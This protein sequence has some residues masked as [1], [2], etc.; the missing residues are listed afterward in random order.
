VP[1]VELLLDDELDG[2]VSGAWARLAAAGLPGLADHRHPT[3]RPHLTLATG[4]ALPAADRLADAL[5]GLPVPVRLAGLLSFGAARGALAWAVV[6]SRAL[7][8]VHA[9]VWAALDEPAP[10]FRPGRWTPH[11]SLA[12][13]MSARERGAAVE[14]LAGLPDAE[15]AL[16]AARSYDEADRTVRELP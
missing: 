7:L 10:W 3:N 2:L 11:V 15:G 13:R 14:L 12:L 16:V 6:P 9:A 5:G 8:D 1:T 4:P